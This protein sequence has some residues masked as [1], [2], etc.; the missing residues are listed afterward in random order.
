VRKITVENVSCE[1]ATADGDVL[2]IKDV[3]LQIAAVRHGAD[4]GHSETMTR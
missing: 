1:F 2:A 4:R 3:P